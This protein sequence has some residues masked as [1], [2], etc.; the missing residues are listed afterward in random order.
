MNNN[1]FSIIKNQGLVNLPKFK[2]KPFD[3]PKPDEEDTRCKDKI[4]EIYDFVRRYQ[5][6][7]EIGGEFVRVKKEINPFHRIEDSS[8]ISMHYGGKKT[9]TGVMIDRFYAVGDIDNIPEEVFC[10]ALDLLKA[11]GGRTTLMD[12]DIKVDL[13]DNKEFYMTQLSISKPMSRDILNLR[14]SLSWYDWF[15]WK[16]GMYDENPPLSSEDEYKIGQALR[17]ETDNMRW[18]I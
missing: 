3:K 10:A 5:F 18:P 2:I 1:W 11:G 6:P 17:Q 7:N 9:G 14:L 15:N 16:D 12:Y 13:D 8:Y 4:M